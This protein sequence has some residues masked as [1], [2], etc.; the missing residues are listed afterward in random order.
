MPA[1][2][3]AKTLERTY[4]EVMEQKIVDLVIVVD[5]ASG[6][7]TAALARQLP[8][9][10]GAVYF[11]S[12]LMAIAL[13]KTGIIFP[14]VCGLWD[15]LQVVRKRERIATL[16]IHFSILLTAAAALTTKSYPPSL[17]Y[18]RSSAFLEIIYTFF[19][20]VGG[21]SFGPSLVDIQT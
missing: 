21:Y 8:D 3:A 17:E 5:D 20:Y 9:T 10:W 14:Y 18:G 2:N 19:T 6:D 1:Y 12:S 16:L 7:S 15:F 4:H 11:L 13:H